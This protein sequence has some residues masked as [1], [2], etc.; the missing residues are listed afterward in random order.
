MLSALPL[1]LAALLCVSCNALAAPRHELS[2]RQ[3]IQLTR[4]STHDRTIEEWGAWARQHKELLETKYSG[5]GGPQQKRSSGTNLLVNQGSDS[6]YYGS[7]AIGTPPVAFDVILDTGSADL[8]VADTNCITGC[9]GVPAFNPSGSSTFTNSSTTFQIA[10]GSGRAA[11]TLGTDVVQMAG[12]SVSNQVFAVCDQV[13]SGLLTSPVSGLLGLGF[14]TIAS[15]RATPFWQTLVSQGAW[16]EPVMAFHLTRF[17]NASSSQTLEP[18]GSFTMGFTNS[19]LYTGNIEYIDLPVAGSYW[20]LP[21]GSLTVQ[22]TSVSLPSGS[23]SYAAI[24]TGTTLVGGPSNIIS[25]MYAQIPGSQPGSGSYEG[26]Y[27]YPCNTDVTVS[28]S[29]G[30]GSSWSISPEDFLLTKLSRSTCLG[31]FFELSTGSSAPNWIFGDTFL[32]N[33]YSAFR[34]SPPAVGFAQLSSQAIQTNGVNGVL[35]TPTIGSAAVAVSATAGTSGQFSGQEV[36]KLSII[37][38]G[39]CWVLSVLAGSVLLY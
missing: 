28:V 11:G 1:S 5:D 38:M 39:T 13:S 10:Y 33:V 31:S 12:F 22:G 8:W 29:F 25:Q 34:Y 21:L 15:S 9:N 35:P 36:S 18:G 37:T 4:K 17:G 19:S 32:K 16:D 23:A 24:D 27:T 26:Y 14:D 7:L 2:A 6:S 30:N 20:I 3:P